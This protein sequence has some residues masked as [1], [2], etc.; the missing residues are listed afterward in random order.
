MILCKNCKFWK[1]HEMKTILI[2]ECGLSESTYCNFGE[3]SND[4]F[5]DC[6][7]QHFSHS[8]AGDSLC[9]ANCDFG[10]Y[11]DAYFCTGENFGCVHG[12]LRDITL[13]VN[14][15]NE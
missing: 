5:L 8:P 2:N 13:D 6:S 15:F 11:G 4:K 10:G 1:R 7:N 3:C 12:E 9:Y 14:D